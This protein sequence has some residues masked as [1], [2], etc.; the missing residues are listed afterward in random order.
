MLHCSAVS[1]LG[2]CSHADGVPYLPFSLKC[3][4]ARRQESPYQGSFTLGYW[5]APPGSSALRL[6]CTDPAASNYAAGGPPAFDDCTYDCASLKAAMGDMD[7]GASFAGA[8]CYIWADDGG[9]TDG[10]GELTA[11]V[12]VLKTVEVPTGTSMIV[13]GH[14]AGN[15]SQLLAVRFAVTA[16]ASC[17]TRTSCQG[18]ARQK[19]ARSR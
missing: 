6:G 13:Q 3:A 19:A 17:V 4:C 9:A 15:V 16:G 8:T 14:T 10:W 18:S 7:R 5:C 12:A 11:T 1:L 2:L